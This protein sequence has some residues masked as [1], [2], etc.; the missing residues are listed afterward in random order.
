MIVVESKK[1]NLALVM[2][3]NITPTGLSKRI[4][5]GVVLDDQTCIN[6]I[7]TYVDKIIDYGGT[8]PYGVV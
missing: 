3:A 1:E 4:E 2:S 5:V 6:K 8:I 7:N